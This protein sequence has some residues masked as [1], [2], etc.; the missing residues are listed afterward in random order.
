ME[1]KNITLIVIS[2]L[3]IGCCPD[4]SVCSN[5]LT[6][7]EKAFVPYARMDNLYF[8]DENG[9]KVR[10][11]IE[12][13]EFETYSVQGGAESCKS[14]EYQKL[15]GAIRFFPRNFEISM[16]METFYEGTHMTLTENLHKWVDVQTYSIGGRNDFSLACEGFYESNLEE[17]LIDI[18]ILDF[19]FENVLVFVNCDENSTISRIIC[20]LNKG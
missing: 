13:S 12:P 7:L 4:K 1:I 20:S 5:K 15:S 2:F 9:N 19:E 11:S 16:E 3:L 6:D 10:A 18:T 14:E 8:A 17:R